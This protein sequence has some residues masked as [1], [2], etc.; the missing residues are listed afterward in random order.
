MVVQH[1]QR[2]VRLD[3]GLDLLGQLR[4]RHGENLDR[5]QHAGVEFLTL[6]G[7]QDRS[8]CLH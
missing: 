7:D 8:L 6:F 5:L 4:D 3:L 1:F 2:G